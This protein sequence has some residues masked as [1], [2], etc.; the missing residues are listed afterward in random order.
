MFGSMG[1]LA[2]QQ[3]NPE[4]MAMLLLS[5]TFL[6]IILLGTL[7]IIPVMMAYLFAPALVVL[8]DMNAWD[9]M[10]ASFMGCLKNVMPL[11]LYSL[12]AFGLMIA[13]MLAF[14]LGLFVVSPIL[15]AAI[16]AA[17]R[18]IFYG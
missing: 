3:A 5:P 12:A 9:A 13:G 18:D 16:Y 10:K 1:E 6:I 2:V 4:A 15:I 8:N 11:F 7:L 14:G 17:Y